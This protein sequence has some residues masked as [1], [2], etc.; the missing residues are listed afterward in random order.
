MRIWIGVLCGIALLQFAR[1]V[2][3]GK[4]DRADLYKSGV[5]DQNGHFSIAG[6]TPCNCKVFAWDGLEPYR[7]FD[8]D[9][10]K[11]YETKGK[12]ILVGESATVNASLQAIPLTP[13]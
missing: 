3:H 12:S 6:I 1:A 8:P 2:P 7:Y 10:M 5:P 4:R 13:E 11:N 9:F